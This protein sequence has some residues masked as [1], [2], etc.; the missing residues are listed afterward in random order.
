MNQLSLFDPRPA[1]P[2]PSDPHVATGDTK[3]LTGQNASILAVLQAGSATNV[4][5]ARISLKYTSRI[6]DL[7]AAGYRIK[8]ERCGDGVNLYTLEL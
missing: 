3:R 2:P 1:S 6:S 8:C 4:M 7:R 5:L